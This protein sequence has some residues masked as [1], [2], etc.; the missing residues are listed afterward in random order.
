MISHVVLMKPRA[1]LAPDQR[2]TF[3]DLFEQALREI[4]SVGGVRIGRRVVHGA[5]YEAL[6]R[7]GFEFRW[8]SPARARA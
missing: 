8:S 1:D 3:V 4:P 6:A 2:R 5:A 7:D